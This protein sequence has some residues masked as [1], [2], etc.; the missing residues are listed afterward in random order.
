MGLIVQSNTSFRPPADQD[1]RT[2]DADQVNLVAGVVEVVEMVEVAVDA[3]P[4]TVPKRRRGRLERMV[5]VVNWLGGDP[6]GD[7]REFH[8]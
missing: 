1:S 4:E 7:I 3:T 2:P 8:K 5:R 6:G